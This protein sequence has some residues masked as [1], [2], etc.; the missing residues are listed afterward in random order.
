MNSKYIQGAINITLIPLL[1]ILLIIG[2]YTSLINYIYPII[3][4]SILSISLTIILSI[5]Y[6]SKKK[7][8]YNISQYITASINIILLFNIIFINNNY[9]Y[10][11]N[12]NSNKYNYLNNEIYVLKNT[13]YHNNNQLTSKKIGVLK[14]NSKNTISL[15][16]NIIKANYIEYETTN[17]MLEDL[18]N[19]K[20]QS[21][22]LNNN[23]T[24]TLKLKSNKIL[25]ETRSIYEIKIKNEI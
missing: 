9:S 18:Y 3:I 16:S 23:E 8:T 13:K 15:M 6:C 22:I 12:I 19:G 21:I 4:V 24:K 5:C 7:L 11:E 20:I 25:K 1:S 10:L 17:E 14:N 2:L